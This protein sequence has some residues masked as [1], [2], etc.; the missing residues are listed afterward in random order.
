MRVISRAEVDMKWH[1]QARIL[2]EVAVIEATGEADAAPKFIALKK[3]P[4]PAQKS[5]PSAQIEKRPAND[6]SITPTAGDLLSQGITGTASSRRSKKR[7]IEAFISIHESEPVSLV[8]GRLTLK[9]KKGMLST[10]RD[11]KKAL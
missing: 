6:A 5:V 11:W 8:N 2:L 7:K 10:K 9:F 3:S 4:M 1:P